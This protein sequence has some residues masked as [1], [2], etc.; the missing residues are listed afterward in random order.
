VLRSRAG[1]SETKAATLIRAKEICDGAECLY[2]SPNDVHSAASET[3]KVDYWDN[4]YMP[5]KVDA[6]EFGGTK[7]AVRHVLLDAHSSEHQ[8]YSWKYKNSDLLQ[9]GASTESGI[10]TVRSSVATDIVTNLVEKIKSSTANSQFLI[11]RNAVNEYDPADEWR[12]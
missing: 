5:I 6:G 4:F 10:N 1:I 11:I 3:A 2:S 12:S 8:L 9:A 7:L